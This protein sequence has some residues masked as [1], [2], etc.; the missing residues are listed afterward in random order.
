MRVRDIMSGDVK[1]CRLDDNLAQVAT[2]MWNNDCGIVP[3]I[4]NAETP[5][6]VI[7]D[8][9]ICI[10]VATK[11]RLASEIPS[12]DAITGDVYACGL[13]DPITTALEIMKERKVRR[14]LIVDENGT[15]R[16]ILSLNDIV[17]HCEPGKGKEVQGFS[18][19]DVIKALQAICEHRRQETVTSAVA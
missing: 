11:Q 13:D 5:I 3:V 8:R 12:T 14:L 9:D 19:H 18:Y 16:G 6:G 4:N 15:L 2:V 10:A 17:L 1:S 7:T